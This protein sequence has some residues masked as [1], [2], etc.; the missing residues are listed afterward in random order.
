MVIVTDLHYLDQSL[1]D[2]GS[3]FE[4]YSANGDG[5]MLRYN[6]DIIDA[7][8]DRMIETKPDILIISGDLTHNGEKI[9]HTAL[10]KKLARIEKEAGTRVY[11]IPGNHDIKN[12]WARAFV[13]DQQIKTKSISWTDFAKIYA[14]FG[15]D[16]ATMRDPVS[17]S[18]LVQPS[19]DLW[20]LMLDSNHYS[21]SK[22]D[23]EPSSN[24]KIQT[25]TLDWIRRMAERAKASGA[26]IL[27]VMHHNLISHNELFTGYTLDNSYDV[28][29]LF[30]ELG[31][32]LVLSGHLHIQDIKKDRFSA[33]PLYDIATESLQMYPFQY[34]TLRYDPHTGFDYETKQ[35]DIEDWAYKQGHTDVN[36]LHFSEYAKTNFYQVSYLK[37]SSRLE[38]LDLYTQTQIDAMASTMALLNLYDFSGRSDEIRDEILSSQ[39]YIEW[40]KA[41]EPEFTQDYIFL[42]TRKSLFDNNRI[43]ID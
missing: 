34:G 5:R 16:E 20:L 1:F 41:T 7:F 3:A 14:A 2:S 19:D 6:N 29:T 26:R 24:G 21:K 17:L 32:N 35:L 9:S 39:G 37:A 33:D 12:A 38:K 40:S 4:K 31:L 13:G 36:L 30:H 8:V 11:V 42:M 22:L 27:T 25:E 23:W 10:A 43:H 15:Y 18:Y 28:K